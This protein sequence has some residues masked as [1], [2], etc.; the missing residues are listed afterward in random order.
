MT[1]CANKNIKR[2]LA[3]VW[4]GQV[5]NFQMDEAGRAKAN[6]IRQGAPL[7]VQ[8]TEYRYL[9]FRSSSTGAGFN[10]FFLLSNAGFLTGLNLLSCPSHKVLPHVLTTN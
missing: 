4:K 10:S 5:E 3:A 9:F 8:L 2:V 6:L 1:K 7:R